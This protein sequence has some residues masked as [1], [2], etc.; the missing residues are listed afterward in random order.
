MYHLGIIDWTVELPEDIDKEYTDLD[1]AY[2]AL[3]KFVHTFD[4]KM[5]VDGRVLDED[6]ED[7]EY[8]SSLLQS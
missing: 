2:E 4:G 6:D 3:S 1:D 5:L 7:V 8:V